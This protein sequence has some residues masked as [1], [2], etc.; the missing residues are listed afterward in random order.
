MNLVLLGPPGAGKGTQ[1]VRLT[2]QYDIPHISTGDIFRENIKN[3]TDL[4]QKAQE[5]MSA[6]ELVPDS[7]VIEIALDRL[8]RDDC[9]NGFLLDGFPRT[10]QQAEA[11]DKYLEGK[12]TALDRVLDIDVEK[13]I[14]VDRLISRRVCKDCGATYNVKGIPPK[15]EGICDVCGGQLQQRADDTEETVNNRIE[16]YDSQTKPL[17]DYYD[18]AGNIAHLDGSIGFE[19]L[20]DEIVK[21]LGA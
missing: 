17:V 13:D 1:A 7:L 19:K 2:K 4:G 18:R 16:V 20:F 10:V 6:G 5:Y 9:K 14:L 21:I 8:D 12:G 3:G 11:L 15:K